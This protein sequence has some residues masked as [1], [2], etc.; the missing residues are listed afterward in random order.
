[1][2][3]SCRARH[4]EPPMAVGRTRRHANQR[5]SGICILTRQPGTHLRTLHRLRRPQAQRIHRPAQSDL[6]LQRPSQSHP[7]TATTHPSTRARAIQPPLQLPQPPNRVILSYPLRS[8]NPTR[9]LPLLRTHLP[10][11]GPDTLPQPHH[12]Y[13]RCPTKDASP[14][15]TPQ[16]PRLEAQH[17]IPQNR[18]AGPRLPHLR[19]QC[20]RGF[21]PGVGAIG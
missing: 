4:P 17:L 21:V 19:A 15:H 20:A 8:P 18:T 5:P 1:M 3:L 16:L 9:P 11:L 12:S 10:S 14:H 6:V 13:N 7:R 2:S